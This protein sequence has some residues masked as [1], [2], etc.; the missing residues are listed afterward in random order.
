M[1]LVVVLGPHAVGKMT[2]GQAL[3][4]KTGLKLLHNHMTIE[5]VREFFPV[6]TS[7]E[8]KRL[9]DLFRREIYEAVAKS[10]LPGLIVTNMI[11]FGLPGQKEYIDDIISLFK[12][13]GAE[14][15]VVELCAD[16]DVRIERNKTENR[17]ANKPSKRDLAQ[18]EALF[19]RL[20]GEYRMNSNPGEVLFENFLKIDNTN[21]SPEDAAAQ[22]C[23][24]FGLET[25]TE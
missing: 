10:D 14:T 22:I 24:A 13:H 12:V 19:R 15:H 6:F 2:V 23:A 11:A 25:I 3:A 7:E 17:L 16:F 5:L 21:L 18:S 9:N 20:E 8:G 1:H 4:A